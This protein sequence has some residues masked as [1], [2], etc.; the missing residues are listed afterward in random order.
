MITKLSSY[1]KE[2]VNSETK[3]VVCSE[4][5]KYSARVLACDLKGRDYN[6]AVAINKDGRDVISYFKPEFGIW[7]NKNG[8]RLMISMNSFEYGDVVYASTGGD[9]QQFILIFGNSE[10]PSISK[11]K[12]LSDDWDYYFRS[13]WYCIPR[14]LATES[15]KKMLFDAMEK[16]A[17]KWDAEKKTVVDLN[18]PQSGCPHFEKGFHEAIGSIIDSLDKTMQFV[19]V[20]GEMKEI[21]LKK[22]HDYGDSFNKSLDEL[23]IVAAVTR[24]SDKIERMKT[25][26]KKEAQVKS[27]SFKDS[28]MDLGIYSIM[29][30]MYMNDHEKK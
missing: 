5:K 8:D 15:E 21:Y 23:G 28:L 25:L 26:V 2:S 11:G 24:M 16:N 29:T 12:Y 14:R 22:N 27:E 30:T 3:L 19:R 4:G 20:T 6:M 9:A 13:Q 17:K 1:K 10:F 18:A 7:T